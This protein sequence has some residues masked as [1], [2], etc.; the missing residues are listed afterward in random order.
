MPETVRAVVVDPSHAEGLAIRPVELPDALP[1][2][3]TVRVTAV[4][5]NRG[6]VRRATSQG[7][8]GDRPG[9]EL[10]RARRGVRRRRQRPTVGSR[11]AGL[12]P[13]GAW[14]ERV[15]APSHAVAGGPGRGDRCAGG[16]REEQ[17]GRRPSGVCQSFS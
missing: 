15:R 7:K 9:L 5:L 16:A 1:D 11:I 14:A 3:V 8:P 6:E 17:D 13:S 4:S 2:Q 10:R 12:L